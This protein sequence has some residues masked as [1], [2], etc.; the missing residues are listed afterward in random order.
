MNFSH[1]RADK[2]LL[3]R[4]NFRRCKEN[5]QHLT[6]TVLQELFN[7]NWT[8]ACEFLCMLWILC[9]AFKYV[10]A[11]LCFPPQFFIDMVITSRIRTDFSLSLNFES[12]DHSKA[13]LIFFVSHPFGICH[14]ISAFLLLSDLQDR[15]SCTY[16]GTLTNHH[17]AL[18]MGHIG[19]SNQRQEPPGLEDCTYPK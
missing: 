3:Q 1:Y 13:W 2:N 4:I 19:L 15:G 14:G 9:V 17:C 8:N 16:T 7:Y 12:R 18:C 5:S 6:N 11:L 10:Y